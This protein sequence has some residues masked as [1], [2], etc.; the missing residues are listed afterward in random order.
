MENDQE[1]VKIGVGLIEGTS[2][3]KKMKGSSDYSNLNKQKE[4]KELTDRDP[5]SITTLIILDN[6]FG[7]N[8]NSTKLGF[9]DV[10]VGNECGAGAPVCSAEIQAPV[11]FKE[12]VVEWTGNYVFNKEGYHP[13]TL[14]ISSGGETYFL[15]DG[16]F[17]LIPINQPDPNDPLYGVPL[18]ESF[19]STY[20]IETCFNKNLNNGKG[21]YQYRFNSVG[22]TD[23]FIHKPIII[24][25]ADYTNDPY[26]MKSL[27]DLNSI[28][29]E[30]ICSALKDFE[31][32]RYRKA[33]Q[34]N[35]N[36]A[37]THD[38]LYRIVEVYWEH[39]KYHKRDGMRFLNDK[40]NKE[41][42]RI[43][44]P[45]GYIISKTLKKHLE[46]TISCSHKIKNFSDAKRVG[47]KYIKDAL[48]MFDNFFTK[49]WHVILIDI[50]HAGQW[51]QYILEELW[52][53]WSDSVQKKI[54]RYQNELALRQGYDPTFCDAELKEIRKFWDPF[55]IYRN[56][57]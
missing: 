32:E 41:L 44:G 9:G 53:H 22:E 36:F 2:G 57:R 55:K 23:N 6:C 49:N 1:T 46:N 19:Y 39:E 43:A 35:D 12:E 8:F 24:Q 56:N 13:K 51:K 33:E 26:A 50:Y 5:E 10:M 7:Q 15:R 47:E 45:D 34:S 18:T 27:N 29:F 30:K 28:P 48:R 11:G 38:P 42:L 16:E 54:T 21:A 4:K 3:E 52:A 40:Y 31:I 14:K 37:N 17:K 25:V 20:E